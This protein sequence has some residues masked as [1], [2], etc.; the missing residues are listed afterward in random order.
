MVHVLGLFLVLV[1]QSLLLL[2]YLLALLL[3]LD[4]QLRDELIPPLD[5]LLQDLYLD[6]EVLVI[7]FRG[8]LVADGVGVDGLFGVLAVLLD[9]ATP[10]LLLV[11]VEVL[12][13][14]LYVV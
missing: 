3:R 2:F 6:H 13:L 8:G 4:L 10:I 12:Y 7:V 1:I 9:Q 11:L 5:L 14:L